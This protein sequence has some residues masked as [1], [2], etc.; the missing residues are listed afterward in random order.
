MKFRKKPVVIE[1]M[2][3][4]GGH[5]S[6]LECAAFI[7]DAAVRNMLRAT[8][9]IR[10]L[11][12]EMS[13]D[14]G[15]W[16]I[17]GVKGEFYPC[18]PD[19][20]VATYEPVEEHQSIPAGATPSDQG[21][22]AS[23]HYAETYSENNVEISGT[24]GKR[25]VL[26]DTGVLEICW[27]QRHG[28]VIFWQLH[29][30][31]H[32]GS[33]GLNRNGHDFIDDLEKEITTLRS[34]LQTTEAARPLPDRSSRPQD[35]YHWGETMAQYAALGIGV[36]A[37]VELTQAEDRANKR[38]FHDLSGVTVNWRT[39]KLVMKVLRAIRIEDFKELET[40]RTQLVQSESRLT[41][42]T[43]AQHRLMKLAKEATNGW[44][45]YAK[46]KIEHDD[47]ARL[48]REIDAIAAEPETGEAR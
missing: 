46:R 26:P 42:L 17:R 34:L 21:A 3:F 1:A 12:G 38:S 20:F 47:I 6:M 9:K 29:S 25:V 48:H 40:L 37:W 8:L 11:E 32:L 43:Q 23:A 44:A 35:T 10:T 45:C 28:A 13:A 31:L 39:F 30:H 33:R 24:F 14:A 5:V 18:K 22:P 2:Q 4:M 27:R 7:G 19:I 15:D 41:S 16:I 36:E